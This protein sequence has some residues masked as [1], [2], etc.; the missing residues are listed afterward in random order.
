LAAVQHVALAL[1]VGGTIVCFLIALV[2]ALT[3]L[4][5]RQEVL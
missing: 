1:A 4:I 5:A 2:I 3:G